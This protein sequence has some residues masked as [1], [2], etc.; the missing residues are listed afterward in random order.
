MLLKL[1]RDFFVDEKSRSAD[2]LSILEEN[3]QPSEI[4]GGAVRRVLNVGGNNK[5]I[6][7]P[8]YFEGWEHLLLD[9]DPRGNPDIICDARLLTELKSSQF[10]AIYCS[11][12][13]EHYYS[14]DAIKVLA[15]FHHVLIDDG[16]VDIRVPDIGK[17]IRLVAENDMDIEDLLY[18]SPAGPI[19]VI[20]VVFGLR[21]EIE[22]SG[23]DF[24]AHKTGFTE[25]SLI[26]Q[27]GES[28]F[29]SVFTSCVGLEVRAIAFKSKPTSD[30]IELLGLDVES[31]S[32]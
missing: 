27:L 17:L 5:E 10:D 31:P 30:L 9:I 12:N 11:H 7:I 18:H 21:S 3:G 22:N 1:L 16:F 20:D 23:N 8:S 14:H 15:G 4:P 19:H 24:F 29:A 26:R 13:L 6:P 2:S 25:K 28:G 32:I